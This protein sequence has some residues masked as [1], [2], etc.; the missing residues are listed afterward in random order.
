MV[1][2]VIESSR[3]LVVGDESLCAQ[4]GRERAA[5]SYCANYL[6]A[7][8]E[9]AGR[10]VDLVIGRIEPMLGEEQATIAALR[11][12]APE[13]RLVLVVR[14]EYEP[15]AMAAVRMGI[16]EYFVEPLVR[17]ELARAMAAMVSAR[18]HEP[19][20]VMVARPVDRPLT[21]QAVAKATLPVGNDHDADAQQLIAQLLAER[22]SV[23]ETVVQI[24]RRRVGPHV[25]WAAEPDLDAMACVPVTYEEHSL[26]YL[27]SDAA[28]DRELIV[29]ADWAA[30][31]MAME[32]R[33]IELKRQAM[34]D[35]LTGAWNRRY[36]HRFLESILRR[37]REQQF[38]VTVMIF[39]IDDFKHYNDK[40]GHAA[41]DEILSEA[42]RLMQTVVRRHD[43]VARIGGDEFA[44]IFWDADAPRKADSK[45]PH[46]VRRAAER[47]QKAI[48]DH[49]FPKLADLAPGTLTISGGLAS[50]PWDGQRG[51]E[52]IKIADDM[53]LQS[54][55][56]GKNA[57][58]FG[59]G[60]L[61]DCPLPQWGEPDEAQ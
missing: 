33:L 20:E 27:I 4:L 16:D 47:F 46:S 10:S 58:I 31:W 61:R 38:R 45:H 35:E 15:Q 18:P 40:Y 19:V 37:A 57:I 8:G 12:L 1:E 17:G 14:A 34:R 54:K 21:E 25:S 51:E 42:A 24:L 59:P 32:Q 44:V 5:A 60:A 3:V 49:K 7:L 56:Q 28:S 26:G 13:A 48:C 55:R 39:D 52:L 43:V 23:A 30:K 41:G 53:L 11:Q 22:G 6:D 9:L 50:Y 29:H 2:Q 36:F